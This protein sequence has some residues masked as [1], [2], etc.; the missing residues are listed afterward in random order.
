MERSLDVLG[1]D[2]VDGGGTPEDVERFE[3]EYGGNPP[4]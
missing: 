2:A 1:V 3:E 4:Q